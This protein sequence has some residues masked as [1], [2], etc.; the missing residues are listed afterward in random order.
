MDVRIEIKRI[1][2]AAKLGKDLRQTDETERYK[3]NCQKSE[4]QKP[5]IILHPAGQAVFKYPF[6]NQKNDNDTADKYIAYE[7]A[8]HKIRHVNCL[9]FLTSWKEGNGACLFLFQTVCHFR[10]MQTAWQ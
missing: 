1:S 6:D 9:L 4:Q 10:Y 5:K 8:Y 2:Q 7:K 3:W